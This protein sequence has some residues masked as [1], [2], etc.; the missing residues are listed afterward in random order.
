MR[1][2]PAW[3][4]RLRSAR[5]ERF[6]TQREMAKHLAEAADEKTALPERE[7]LV[8]MIRD[9]EAGKHQ[10]KDP[11]RLLY[12]RVFS[13]SEAEL[14]EADGVE[15][16][17]QDDEI[18]AM[19][20]A[21]RAS[22]SD[23]GRETIERLEAAV[24]E[25]AVAYPTTP[26]AELLQR[27]R[28]HLSYVARL[29]DV[30]TTL[31]ERRQLLVV[32]GWLS[33]L[34]AT[35][36]IDLRQF[37]AGTA[38]LVT[39]GQL[40]KQAD[41]AEIAAWCLETDAWQAVTVGDYR[42]ALPLTQAAQ[43]IAPRASS[44]YIQATAQEG[45][46]WAR[47]GEVRETRD[48]LDRLSRLVSP[49]STPDNPEHH[50]RY[51]PAKSDAYVATTLS[52][53]GDSAAVPYARRV[54]ARMESPADGPVRPRRAVAARLDLALALL[55]VDQSEEAGELALAAITSGLLVPSNY[56]RAREVVAEID[57]RRI[58]EAVQLREAYR[59]LCRVADQP[60]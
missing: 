7:S 54:L 37:S 56:W 21:R 58:P 3:A 27:V 34:A 48:A 2:V 59:E 52:W 35:C 6:W 49:L 39:A 45:R 22:A 26:P 4:A 55:A 42:R 24:D 43:A 10:P 36:H 44:A 15:P 28:V 30:K 1:D 12:C 47:L 20:L 40:A 9:W 5:R 18:D 33:L 31:A 51:D 17:G 11:Y 32:G 16:S 60:D 46:V 19:D 41:H 14:F 8:R 23:V 25:L 38:R 29:L 50:Y 13:V 53:L 57:N